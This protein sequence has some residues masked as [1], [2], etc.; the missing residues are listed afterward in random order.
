MRGAL[1]FFFL[2][3][4]RILSYNS[5]HVGDG[6][7]ETR[8]PGT[9]RRAHP[10]GREKEAKEPTFRSCGPLFVSASEN[11][12]CAHKSN[13]RHR[14]VSRYARGAMGRRKQR[15]ARDKGARSRAHYPL[16]G[17]ATDKKRETPPPRSER[18]VPGMRRSAAQHSSLVY[19]IAE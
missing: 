17:C 15:E 9:R 7:Y 2:R 11:V 8:R 4:L 19:F 10:E 5:H 13:A 3:L 14:F 12:G 18:D 6:L 1:L 16:D